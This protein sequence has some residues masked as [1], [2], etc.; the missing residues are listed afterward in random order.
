MGH[1]FAAAILMSDEDY[2]RELETQWVTVEDTPTA[3]EARA[4][5]WKP[6]PWHG[7]KARLRPATLQV[8][9]ELEKLA[10]RG[11]RAAEE[12][13][14]ANV[15]QVLVG[16]LDQVLLE[17]EDVEPEQLKTAKAHIAERFPRLVWKLGTMSREL[18]AS[19]SSRVEGE[20]GN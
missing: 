12:S 15:R 6:E 3:D 18:A 7:L 16:V 13:N 8:Q 5:E 19:V 17:L 11:A 4:G 1:A 9:T 2:R 14:A 20:L 10:R